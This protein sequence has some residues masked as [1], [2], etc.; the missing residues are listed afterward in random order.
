MENAPLRIEPVRLASGLSWPESPRWRNGELFLSDVH[1]YRVAKVA[2]DGFVSTVCPVEGRPAGI[3]FASDGSLLLATGVGRHLLRVNPENGQTEM[4][5]DVGE[6]AKAYLNDLII[7]E[8]GWAWFGD[9]GFRFGIDA[10]AEN[11]SLWAFHSDHGARPVASDLAF[12]NGLVIT[13]DNDKLYVAET[14]GQRIS[15]FDIGD[16]GALSNRRILAH[17][18]DRPDGICMDAEGCLWVSL[19]FRGDFLRIAQDGREVDRIAFPGKSAIS[20]VIGGPDRRTLY[21]CVSTMGRDVDGNPSRRGE[22]FAAN[23][24]VVGAG[25]P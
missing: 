11:G 19:L 13:P 2:M 24:I 6:R 18:P 3:D 22:V 1:N 25:R 4:L 7:H 16:A 21:M 5:A 15:V 12:P 20:C 14:F 23:P 8:S 10:P 17:L 9:T